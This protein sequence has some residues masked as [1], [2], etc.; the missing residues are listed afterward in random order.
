LNE[1]QI[2][3]NE[4]FGEIRTV[5]INN[6]A[7]F[8]AS[9]IAKALG[10]LKPNDAISK[11]CRATTKWSTPISGKMQEV[12]FIPEG[13]IYRLITKSQLPSAEKFE[14]WVFDE[15]LPTIRKH[16]MYAT[17]ELLDNPDLLIQVATAL[18]AEREKN[19]QLETEVKV[20]NQL[21]GE[22]KPKADYVDRILQNSGLVTITQIA[23][24][25]GMSGQAMNELLH[26]LKV[27]YKQS[28]QWLL[29]SKYHDQGYTHSKTV[30]IKH[31]DGTPDVKMNTKW[32]QKGRLFL[33]ELLKYNGHLPTIEQLKS[34]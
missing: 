9:D 4:A 12:N 29:Y 6:K 3:K 24:D 14:A 32:T 15:V 17:D 28:E 10:Y 11:H 31:K 20:K 18:K 22:L 2:F 30:D 16:G 23:K 1:L 19:K 8:M 13:D 7:Y 33:Y 21:I 5:E 34:A 27:Q 26:E 25:Y